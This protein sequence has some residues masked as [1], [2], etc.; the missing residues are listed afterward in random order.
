MVSPDIQGLGLNDDLLEHYRKEVGEMALGIL[1]GK[2]FDSPV[3]E[4][5]LLTCMLEIL[6][7]DD[8][9]NSEFSQERFHSYILLLRLVGNLW[10]QQPHYWSRTCSCDLHPLPR[11]G[12]LGLRSGRKHARAN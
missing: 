7:Y 2:P 11:E 8:S 10:P 5:I 1:D 12:V 3:H 4:G 6:P 9:D